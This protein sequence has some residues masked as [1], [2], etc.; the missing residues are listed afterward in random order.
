LILRD[1]FERSFLGGKQVLFEPAVSL[2]GAIRGGLL[3]PS[4]GKPRYRSLIRYARP[5]RVVRFG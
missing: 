1:P 3:E 2:K 5:L 4:L